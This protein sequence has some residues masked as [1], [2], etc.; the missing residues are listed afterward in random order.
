MDIR[1]L[2]T[3]SSVLAKPGEKDLTEWKW[4]WKEKDDD[5][6]EYKFDV[7]C[8]IIQLLVRLLNLSIMFLPKKSEI[9]ITILLKQTRYE[10]IRIRFGV[11]SSLRSPGASEKADIAFTNL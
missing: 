10:H 11:V 4:Y 7:S 8:F 2:S 1:R 9:V 3:K 5:W 6:H